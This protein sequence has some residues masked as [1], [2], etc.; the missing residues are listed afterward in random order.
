M[1]MKYL[2][3]CI[4]GL[5]LFLLP[6]C[7]KPVGFEYR[8]IKNFNIRNLGVEKSTVSM[9]LVYFNPNNFGVNLK[10]VKCD[11]YIDSSY[12]GQFLLDTSMLIPGKSE[13]TLPAFMNIN[14]KGLLKNSMQILFN[15]ELNIEAKGTTRVGKGGIFLTIPFQYKGKQKLN[16]F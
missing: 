2:L 5:T 11:I 7:K 15:K 9:D 4:L 12:L 14:M 13:F 1:S 6:S 3:P 16:F 8:D 10:N